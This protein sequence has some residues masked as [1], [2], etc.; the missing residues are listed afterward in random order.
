MKI[1]NGCTAS[2]DD[3]WYD[4]TIGGYLKPENILEDQKDIKKVKEAIEILIEF[5]MSCNEQITGFCM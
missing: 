4:L 2:T 5:E 1:K 3:F